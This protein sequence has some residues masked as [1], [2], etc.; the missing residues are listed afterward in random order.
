MW[1]LDESAT[2]FL[3]T[4]KVSNYNKLV[5]MNIYQIDNKNTMEMDVSALWVI[6]NFY[7]PI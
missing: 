5:I 4:R 1:N 7:R 6:L 2:D 3:Y